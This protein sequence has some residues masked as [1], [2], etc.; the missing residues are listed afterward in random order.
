[1]RLSKREIEIAK[2]IAWGDKESQ[3]AEELF[4]SVHTF[5]THRKNI[6]RKI[7]GHN[8]QDITRWYFQYKTGV[9]FGFNPRQVKRIAWAL[10]ALMVNVEISQTDLIRPFRLRAPRPAARLA[11]ARQQKAPRKTL[12]LQ[13]A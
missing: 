2:L 3:I 4:I 12:K 7:K 13:Y 10:L 11:R 9:F 6:L 5:R 8:S 1:M